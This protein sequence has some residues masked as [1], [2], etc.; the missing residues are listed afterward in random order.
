MPFTPIHF[1]PNILLGLPLYRRVD[2]VALVL[3]SVVVDIEPLVVMLLDLD[4]PL[5]GY[6]HTLLIGSLIGL[7][8]GLIL[9]AFRTTVTKILARLKLAHSPTLLRSAISGVVGAW[10]HVLYDAPIYQ[11]IRPFFPID[12][13]PMLGVIDKPTAYAAG[14]AAAAAATMCYMIHLRKARYP[15]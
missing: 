1:G 8:V 14:L 3:V 9:Y 11:D 12:S 2:F 13:N 6:C 15:H 5:H 4:Y 10:L 7:L